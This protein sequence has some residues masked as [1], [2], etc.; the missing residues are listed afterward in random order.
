MAAT[1]DAKSDVGTANQFEDD[2]LI[3]AEKKE[4]DLNAPEEKEEEEP[5]DDTWLFFLFFVF[6]ILN[7]VFAWLTATCLELLQVSLVIK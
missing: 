1:V 5:F 2:E 4:S 6:G 3:P 7:I